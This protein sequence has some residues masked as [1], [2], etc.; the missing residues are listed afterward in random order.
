MYAI[1]DIETTGGHAH[2]NG[3]TEI[4]IVIHNGVNV[5]QRYQQLVNPGMPIPVY[6]QALTGISQELVK[7]A[8]PFRDIAHEV[9][10]LLHDKIFVAHNV[11]FDYSFLKFHLAASGFDLNCRKLCTVRLGR[12]I[13]PGL[14]SY[15][16]GKFTRQMGVEITD[17]HRAGGD[18]EATAI[19][20]GM[21][22]ANDKEG[23]IRASLNRVSKEQSLPPH[24]PGE[25]VEALP[26][27]PGVY[28][29]H[30]GKGKVV[31]VGKARNLKKR[32]TSHFSNNS[33]G[34]QKQDFLRSIHQ[35]SYQECGTEL[36]AFILES[37]EIRRLWP[38][39]NRAQKR[40]SH[41]WG[42]YLFEDQNGYLRIGIDR[43]RK[44]S[45]PVYTF[46]SVGDGHNLLRSLISDF[47]LCPK[48]CFVQRN[49]QP[50]TGKG[51][52]TCFGACEGT[53]DAASYNLR[54]Q[55][56]I[57]RLQ[58]ALPTYAL[59][60]QGRSL[61]EDS[62]ILIEKGQFYG[63]GYLPKNSRITDPDS[64]KP[65]LTPYPGN[66]YIRNMVHHYAEQNPQRK[67]QFSL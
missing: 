52:H 11:N 53:E 50:C 33:P 24:L 13:W 5:T 61:A 44:Y 19:L 3:I 49:R 22:L 30:N 41:A 1:V 46:H 51:E 40:F 15:S 17:R 55:E 16:L 56:A 31:Y 67:V 42:F 26:H 8:P 57:T 47:N 27:T 34:R 45:F 29:F 64:L 43:K 66:D 9:Y 65:A 62:C 10:A 4:A 7:N 35:V 38:E 37:V 6:I 21:M 18:A 28:Y 12:K 48:L 2:A 58:A 32:V 59:F 20:F 54:V 60:G 25:Q 63:M 23:H 36:M 14:P 39:H